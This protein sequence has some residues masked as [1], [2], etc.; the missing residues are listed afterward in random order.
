[1][2]PFSS[3]S[4]DAKTLMHGVVLRASAEQTD[5]SFE[6]LEMRGPLSP[7]PHVH[8]THDEVF[9]VLSGDFEFFVGDDT[10]RAHTG[11]MVV[12]PSGTSHTFEA[13]SDAR[14]LV[15]I[16]PAGLQGFFEELGAAQAAGKTPQETRAALQ[17]RYDSEPVEMKTKRI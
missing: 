9:Y 11:T 15:L 13:A 12:V 4:G 14:T 8:R 17:D 5:G 3:E 7:P 6:I 1:M 16:A 10:I 2:I